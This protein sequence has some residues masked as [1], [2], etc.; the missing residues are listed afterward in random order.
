MQRERDGA[1]TCL[2]HVYGKDK[3]QCA[4]AG[5]SV[6][7]RLPVM[8]NGINDVGEEGGVPV[9]VDVAGGLPE[10]PVGGIGEVLVSEVPDV[11][12][13]CGLAAELDGAL[14]PKNVEGFLQVLGEDVGG[15]LDGGNGPVFELDD[16]H[17]HVLGLQVMVELLPGQA[18][19]LVDVITE[20]PAEEVNTVDALVHEC[21]AVLCPGAAPGSLGIV[22][23]VAVPADMNG[24]VGKP[25]EAAG[26]E[27]PA[28]FL[29]RN[30]EAVLVA[31][32]DLDI[33]FVRE[34]NDPV[35][36]AQGHGHGFLDDDVDAVFNTENCDF[37]MKPAFGG[38][39]DKFGALFFYH[40]LVVFILVYGRNIF[41]PVL[42]EKA[43]HV[44]WDSVTD[45]GNFEGVVE[46]SGDVVGR[47]ASASYEC[48]FHGS[49]LLPWEGR[50]GGM[51]HGYH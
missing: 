25:A 10:A 32:G 40:G 2:A 27:C 48:V 1:G 24:T 36:V 38:D 13:V 15:A 51:W 20:G 28:H 31:C 39:A 35:S 46:G 7:I 47:D 23:A 8:Q 45:S 11:N 44:L 29:D 26:L 43:F 19:D 5:A 4:P 49:E 33:F 22:V 9:A 37:G 16:S 3:F 41:Q 42:P 17:A 21:A 18:V 6:D 50:Q 30:V 14:F 12:V 34:G